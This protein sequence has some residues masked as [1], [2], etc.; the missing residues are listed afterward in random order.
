MNDVTSLSRKEYA[1]DVGATIDTL[2][3]I[4]QKLAPSLHSH[5]PIFWYEEC[6]EVPCALDA[7]VE[8]GVGDGVAQLDL[9]LRRLQVAHRGQAQDPA[10][11][12]ATYEWKEEI[13]DKMKIIFSDQYPVKH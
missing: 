2:E 5:F 6:G 4:R 10:A 11:G 3:L 7:D 1:P 12:V 13:H 9:H 8:E